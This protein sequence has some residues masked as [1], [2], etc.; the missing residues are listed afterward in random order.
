MVFPSP[1]LGYSSVASWLP[2]LSISLH[3]LS[4][5]SP[6]WFHL[7]EHLATVGWL[8][9]TSQS[10]CLLSQLRAHWNTSVLFAFLRRWSLSW[11]WGK[12]EVAHHYLITMP[13]Q[14]CTVVMEETAVIKAKREPICSWH[15]IFLNY[16]ELN[17]GAEVL[18]ACSDLTQNKCLLPQTLNRVQVQKINIGLKFP[19][20]NKPTPSI[21]H[22][23]QNNTIHS[24]QALWHPKFEQHRSRILT[25][26]QMQL[27]VS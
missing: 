25:I 20:H 27:P 15:C 1:A 11:R 12:Y 24:C 16:M 18:C 21:L 19:Q 2:G 9:A 10:N 23:A 6:A 14:T 17:L 3:H 26:H 22:S 5:S 13:H 7:I 4:P 8:T